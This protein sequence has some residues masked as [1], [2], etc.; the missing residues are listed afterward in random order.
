[1]ASPRSYWMRRDAR[2][3][4]ADV[5][6]R[7]GH[8]LATGGDDSYHYGSSP[9]YEEF[10]P[11]K[12]RGRRISPRWLVAMRVAARSRERARE[13]RPPRLRAVDFPGPG[14]YFARW[15]ADARILFSPL[16]RAISRQ[17]RPRRA[18]VMRRPSCSRRQNARRCRRRASPGRFTL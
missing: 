9:Q 17:F 11:R 6:I 3:E 5:G 16:R 4:A 7:D 13:Y 10:S 1:M 8:G 18:G 15:S 12:P 14:A 2:R